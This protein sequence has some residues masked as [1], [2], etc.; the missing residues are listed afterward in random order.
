MA[1]KDCSGGRCQTRPSVLFGNHR[2]W[3]IDISGSGMIFVHVCVGS[4]HMSQCI[5]VFALCQPIALR[6]AW[7]IYQPARPTLTHALFLR[8]IHCTAPSFRA[9]KF[10]ELVQKWPGT[11]MGHSVNS[12]GMKTLG[13]ACAVVMSAAAVGL[14]ASLH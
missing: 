5:L 1:V 14:L 13:W 6:A 4:V 8:M 9:Q 2:A 3:R 12:T 11:P 7:L 10:P